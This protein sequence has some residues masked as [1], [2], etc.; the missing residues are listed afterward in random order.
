MDDNELNVFKTLFNNSIFWFVF[1]VE[2]GLTH[3]MLFLGKT[4]FGHTVLGMT[5]LT[6][7]Q[8]IV[9]W[10]LALLSLPVAVLAK[11]V[12]PIKPFQS[13][14]VKLDLEPAMPRQGYIT[15]L[16]EKAKNIIMRKNE[17]DRTSDNLMKLS[18]EKK[19]AVY[20]A[21]S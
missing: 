16:Y 12:V 21:Y 18:A 19:S 9:C 20:T 4:T 7:I 13:L 5:K 6:L 2:M 14:L 17:Q 8:Y 1:L 11:K 15:G 3:F 10:L